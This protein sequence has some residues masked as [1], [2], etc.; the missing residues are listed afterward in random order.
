MYEV[1]EVQK[2]KDREKER[3][4]A[5]RAC[6]TMDMGGWRMARSRVCDHTYIYTY[7]GVKW[8]KK[9]EGTI[10]WDNNSIT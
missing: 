1:V 8:K 7:Y 5:G 6:P 10:C 9:R 2:E 4:K 3:E